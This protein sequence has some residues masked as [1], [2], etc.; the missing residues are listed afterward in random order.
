MGRHTMMFYAKYARVRYSPIISPAPIRDSV[1][2]NILFWHHLNIPRR[3]KKFYISSVFL[4]F[5][6][7][8]YLY[9]RLFEN[10]KIYS[11]K[12]IWNLYR[13]FGT[14]MIHHEYLINNKVLYIIELYKFG[15]D[16]IFVQ[17]Y[18]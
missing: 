2:D 13:I 8:I 9:P 4:I 11:S 6:Y 7:I 1:W 15:L 10:L 18:I 17:L 5:L 12:Y 16:F 3:T 14:Q